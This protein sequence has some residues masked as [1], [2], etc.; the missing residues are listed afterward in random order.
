MAD[1]PL[2]MP[3][4]DLQHQE[5]QEYL[6]LHKNAIENYNKPGHP[7]WEIY[8]FDSVEFKT[9]LN[10]DTEHWGWG[11]SCTTCAANHILFLDLLT[12]QCGVNRVRWNAICETG[13]RDR[14]A[15]VSCL[16]YFKQYCYA[17]ATVYKIHVK[18]TALSP[19]V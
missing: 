13:V 12:L 11:N 4:K 7:G 8:P 18:L 9:V 1:T 17:K 2:V 19:R 3:C 10:I 16:S 14:F 6:N 5:Q 15:C